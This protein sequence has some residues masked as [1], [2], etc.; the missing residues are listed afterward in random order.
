MKMIL[1]VYYVGIHD[2][3][4]E[5]LDEL[6]VCTFT[7][8]R[9]VEGRI[10]CGDPREG[11]QVWPGTNSALMVVVEARVADLLLRRLEEF[12]REREEEGVDAHVLDVAQTVMAGAE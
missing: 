3:V 2:E 1:M 5:L 10:S 7:R 12:N 6:G 4:M 11:T 9:E 8:W